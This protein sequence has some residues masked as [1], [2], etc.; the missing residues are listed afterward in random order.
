MRA[1]SDLKKTFSEKRGCIVAYIRLLIRFE[2]QIDRYLLIRSVIEF[3]SC[4]P[5]ILF[6][7]HSSLLMRRLPSNIH[8]E[9]CIVAE[10]YLTR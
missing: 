2:A 8:P 4:N 10:P 7:R 6:L 3:A 5:N 9:A 1:L